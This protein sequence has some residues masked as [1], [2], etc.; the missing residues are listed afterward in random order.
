MMKL[1]K[2]QNKKQKQIDQNTLLNVFKLIIVKK[3]QKEEMVLF[4]F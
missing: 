2:F 1:G 3:S 4:H